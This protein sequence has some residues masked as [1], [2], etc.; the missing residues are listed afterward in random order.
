MWART[1]EFMLACWLAVSPFIFHYPSEDRFL[2]VS[3]LSCAFF[4]ALF[5]LLSFSDRL[6]KIHYLNLIVATWLW[7]S[8]YDNFPALALPP[9]E[10]SVAIGL[11][12]LMLAMVPSHAHLPPR[13][14]EKFHE[15]KKFSGKNE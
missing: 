3:H 6:R 14:W 5:S 12:L 4:T 15:G 8:G 10:N 2:W 11:L 7:F 13:S 1:V 9:Q